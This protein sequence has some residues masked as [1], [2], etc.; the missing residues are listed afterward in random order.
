MKHLLASNNALIVHL[1]TPTMDILTAIDILENTIHLFDHMYD[2]HESF[3]GIIEVC[4]QKNLDKF[5]VSADLDAEFQ[6]LRCRNKALQ[7]IQE[8]YQITFQKLIIHMNDEFKD[9]LLVLT[10]NIKHFG[11]LSPKQINLF[12][13]EDANNICSVVSDIDDPDLLFHEFQLMKSKIIE[14]DNIANVL[15]TIR[16]PDVYPRAHKVLQYVLT[17]PISIA[18]NER[19]FSKLKIVK[20][21]FRTNMSDQRLFYLM[22]YA[23]E[24]DYL[25]ELN[26][27]DLAKD[28][29]KMK[30]RR[31]ELP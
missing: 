15:I 9:Y 11:H 10:T 1:Q 29:A 31:I 22:F 24:K 12:S 5:N 20:N 2:D 6:C 26:L 4:I 28:W 3:R 18:S 17:I 25:D 7:S 21:Y 19:S 16:T 27:Y 23:I 13:R 14:S 30:D 8:Y